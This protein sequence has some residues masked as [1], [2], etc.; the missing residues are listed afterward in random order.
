V[1]KPNDSAGS[2]GVSIC[3]SR[4]EV[5][6]AFE[7]LHGATNTLGLENR[8]VLL[9]EYLRGDEYVVDTVSRDCKHKC[10]AIWKYDKRVFY[11]APVVYY[12]MRLMTL[13][14]KGE[15]F[16]QAMVDYIF[17]VLDVLGI[18]KGAV[19]SEIKVENEKPRGPVLIEANCRLHGGDGSWA[20]VSQKCLGYSDV[21]A[22][23]DAYMEPSTFARLP[24][25]R[26]AKLGFGAWLTMRSPVGALL[27]ARSIKNV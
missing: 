19:Q 14:T 1:V 18:K 6:E 17:G 7:R 2:D 11:G 3:N 24:S 4:E 12:E 8:S 15:P 27:K 25:S 5:V 9:Q 16:L 23:I 22:L 21:S 13:G 20:P 10:V 26:S